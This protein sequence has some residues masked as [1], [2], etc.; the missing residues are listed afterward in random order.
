MSCCGGSRDRKNGLGP[1]G[2]PVARTQKSRFNPAKIKLVLLGDSGVGK[3][4]IVQRF[5]SDEFS[6]SSTQ[7]L[8]LWQMAFFVFMTCFP[9]SISLELSLNEIY[10]PDA[11]VRKSFA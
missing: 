2:L 3:T 5:A 8:N 10:F 7:F 6:A 4:C 11:C 9:I 1:D